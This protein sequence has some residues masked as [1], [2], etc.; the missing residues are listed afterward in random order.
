LL[1][2]KEQPQLAAGLSEIGG[3]FMLAQPPPKAVAGVPRARNGNNSPLV[4]RFPVVHMK[5]WLFIGEAKFFRIHEV[6]IV[7]LAQKM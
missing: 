4:N 2:R 3:Y 7:T 6:K 1:P 5:N